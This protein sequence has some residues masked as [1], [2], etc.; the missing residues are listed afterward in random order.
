MRKLKF[1]AWDK[2]EKQMSWPFGIYATPTWETNSGGYTIPD[3]ELTEAPIM[4]FTGLLDKNGVEIYEGDIVRINSIAWE[5]HWNE[6][7]LGF[8]LMPYSE[9]GP[10]C[11]KARDVFCCDCEAPLYSKAANTRQ[12]IEIIGDIHST[13]EL[14]K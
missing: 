4:Q 11:N 1:R 12:E 9:N 3:E 14:F 5:V 8:D 2:D 10:T 13:P 7:I 6:Y